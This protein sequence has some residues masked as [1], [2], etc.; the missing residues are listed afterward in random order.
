[1]NTC[2]SD[3]SPIQD[4]LDAAKAAGFPAGFPD[5]DK[6][7]GQKLSYDQ[8]RDLTE[9]SRSHSSTNSFNDG[10]V[11]LEE[12][13]EQFESRRRSEMSMIERGKSNTCGCSGTRR[14]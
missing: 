2:T 3:V 5:S 14:A 12:L 13:E 9:S 1:M 6:Q 10:T 7:G 11:I 4:G 8:H